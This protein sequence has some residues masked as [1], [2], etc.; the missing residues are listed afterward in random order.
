MLAL[1][2]SQCPHSESHVLLRGFLH[3]GLPKPGQEVHSHVVFASTKGI[4]GVVNLREWKGF[5]SDSNV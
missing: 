2:K 5:L 1:E 3:G 4:D